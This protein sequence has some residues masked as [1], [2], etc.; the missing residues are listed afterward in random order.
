VPA[1]TPE[2]LD[3]LWEFWVEHPW[4]TVAL[5]AGAAGFLW[6]VVLPWNWGLGWSL[7][8]GGVL[9][10]MAF[11]LDR[12]GVMTEWQALLQ[13]VRAEDRQTHARK[14]LEK[15]SRNHIKAVEMLLQSTGGNVNLQDAQGRTPL[16]I[17]AKS[18]SL[19]A[20]ELLL[21]R[22]ADP[23]LADAVDGLTPLMLAARQGS[24]GMAMKLLARGADVL[25]VDIKKQR[26]LDHASV[27]EKK[28]QALIELLEAETR[29]AE[30]VLQQKLAREAE[31][32]KKE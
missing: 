16:W 24:L 17:A 14:P 25:L 5:G 9:L 32:E 2:Q 20:V 30:I 3:P 22:G 10:G 11:R 28:S 12:S 6:I 29:K 26:A 18:G 21:A 7:L 23:G 19:E 4:G 13:Q 31:R 15:A 8:S 1:L 27:A